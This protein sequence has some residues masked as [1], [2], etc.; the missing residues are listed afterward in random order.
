M[1]LY[2]PLPLVVGKKVVQDRRQNSVCGLSFGR[3]SGRTIA[4]DSKKFRYRNKS[5]VKNGKETRP[6]HE[7]IPAAASCCW[8]G[9]GVG[10]EA[11]FSLWA[12][13]RPLSWEDHC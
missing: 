3:S 8:Q 11:K 10:R 1:K 7:N 2:P 4:D 12:E 13:F 6:Y 5:F 9:G